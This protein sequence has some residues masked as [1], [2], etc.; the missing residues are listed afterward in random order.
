MRYLVRRV[1]GRLEARRLNQLMQA[2]E[3]SMADTYASL[4][5]NATQRAVVATPA[6][7]VSVVIPVRNEERF[8]RPLLLQV[9][10]QSYDVSR[11]E[12]IV[13]DG[14]SSD[15]TRQIVLDLMC[16]YANLLL[17]DNPQRWSSSGRNAA[18]K[19]SRGEIIVII[20]G[21]CV[22]PD[23]G[24]LQA[25]VSAFVRSGADCL[26][27]PQPLRTNEATP[28]QLAVAH[29]RSSWL[30][31]HP[32]SYVY[33]SGEG[34][35]PPQ[36]VAVAYRRHLFADVGLFDESFDACE[37]VEFNQRLFQAHARCFFS[38][39]IAVH[40]HP[41]AS[42][43]GL[44]Q[45]MIR[46]GKGRMRLLRKHP[47]TVSLGSVLPCC[48]L[49]LGA[50]LALGGLWSAGLR[51]AYLLAVVGY[52]LTVAATALLVAVRERA[53]RALPWLPL[54]FPVIH[55]GVAVG[56]LLEAIRLLAGP[57]RPVPLV[58]VERLDT[59]SDE[60]AMH[61]RAA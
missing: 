20:D 37:D 14:D 15:G 16:K 29:A 24:Y 25:I 1:A 23:S 52:C 11:F 38:D 53:A 2:V 33:A 5:S 32:D 3:E 50:G 9:L 41:R 17:V 26:G 59:A 21:H 47:E 51:I 8:L 44:F 56:L 61:R 60:S 40:Y 34:F 10:T 54:V 18:I 28:L 46:Y 43:L 36:S 35:V 7:F 31:H 13:A 22:L 27:R 48:C 6:P 57:L 12:V 42:L 49:V 30:G 4:R 58:V 45:Q 19:R 39:T 55:V